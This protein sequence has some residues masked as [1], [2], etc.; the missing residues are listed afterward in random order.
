M[1]LFILPVAEA[2]IINGFEI[3]SIIQLMNVKRQKATV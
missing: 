2:P 1:I 3:D